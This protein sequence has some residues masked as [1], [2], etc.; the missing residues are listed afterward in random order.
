MDHILSKIIL[1]RCF[2]GAS[3]TD[4]QVK[5]YLNTKLHDQSSTSRIH[6][7]EGKNN[8]LK[9]SCDLI[10]QNVCTLTHTHTH[11]HTHTDKHTINIYI[12]TY[13]HTLLI[14]KDLLCLEWS[15][16]SISP[17]YETK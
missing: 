5:R 15:Y 7:G 9:L 17:I 3:G 14:S 8:S 6:I 13:I 1:K 4:L 2:S 10:S 16:S 12:C 11:T